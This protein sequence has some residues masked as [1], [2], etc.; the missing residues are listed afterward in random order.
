MSKAK[1][2]EGWNPVRGHKHNNPYQA[3]TDRHRHFEQE[4]AAGKTLWGRF[5]GLW[6]SGREAREDRVKARVETFFNTNNPPQPLGTSYE[7]ELYQKKN[8]IGSTQQQGQQPTVYFRSNSGTFGH[9]TQEHPQPT[10]VGRELAFK[11]QDYAI[12][13]NPNRGG[14]ADEMIGNRVFHPSRNPFVP[15]KTLQQKEALSPA[16]GTFTDLKPRY[17]SNATYQGVDNLLRDKTQYN[18][19]PHAQLYNNDLNRLADSR[20]RAT[21]FTQSVGGNIPSSPPQRRKMSAG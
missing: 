15:A 5:K 1:V 9:I 11:R 20:K 7:G 2:R 14:K 6:K 19:R 8:I 16:I 13:N 4:F 10:N 3:G 18:Q 21:S 12:T 17:R